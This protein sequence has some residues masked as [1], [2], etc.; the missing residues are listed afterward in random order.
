MAIDVDHEIAKR[1]CDVVIDKIAEVIVRW[2]VLYTYD[3]TTKNCQHF[4]EDLL[5][6]LG[7]DN[8]L[9]FKGAMGQFLKSMR[10]SHIF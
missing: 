3:K 5:E 9:A 4:V 2:N 1:D 8:N 7:I 10:Y 6:E